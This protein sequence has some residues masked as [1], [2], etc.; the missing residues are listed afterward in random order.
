MA[1]VRA[2]WDWF[3]GVDG[4]ASEGDDA[5]RV[6]S[7]DDEVS[8]VGGEAS[9]ERRGSVGQLPQLHQLAAPPGLE[10]VQR[11][12]LPGLLR[13]PDTLGGHRECLVV[14]VHH[15]QD[16]AAQTAGEPLPGILAG[17]TLVRSDASTRASAVSK[18]PRM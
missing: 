2:A 5:A 7:A 3:A 1:A 9:F 6:E 12:A 14:A 13:R 17:P 4:H 10:H 15:G 16:R 8:V 11:P 18:R